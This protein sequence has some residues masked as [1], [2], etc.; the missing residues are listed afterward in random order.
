MSTMTISS[1]RPAADRLVFSYYAHEALEID[2]AGSPYA[3]LDLNV[4]RAARAR[5]LEAGELVRTTNGR[6]VPSKLAKG[7]P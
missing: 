4:F 2:N 3:G 7:S 5:L 6:Y 1:Q